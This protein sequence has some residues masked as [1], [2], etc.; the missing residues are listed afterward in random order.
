MILQSIGWWWW[1]IFDPEVSENLFKWKLTK[2]W[3]FL[4]SNVIWFDK[5]RLFCYLSLPASESP[6][7]RTIRSKSN[8]KI[9]GDL[10]D[11][12]AAE[13]ETLYQWPFQEPKLE[14]PTIYKAYVRPM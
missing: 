11:E 2:S 7:T 9:Y 5:R 8:A 6:A 10:E 13:V 4:H 12:L 14:V 1:L 3:L